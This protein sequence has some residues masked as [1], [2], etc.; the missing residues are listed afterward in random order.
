M[1]SVFNARMSVLTGAAEAIRQEADTLIAQMDNE[2]VFAT[3]ARA[4][5]VTALGMGEERLSSPALPAM[6]KQP[7]QSMGFTTPPASDFVGFGQTAEAPAAAERQEGEVIHRVVM[8]KNGQVIS[9][10][11]LDSLYAPIK[12]ESKPDFLSQSGEA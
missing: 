3:D 4:L 10:T 5:I 2:G 7:A 9:S 11:P 1:Q 12:E 8:D 6:S